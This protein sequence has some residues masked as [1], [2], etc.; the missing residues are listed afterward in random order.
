MMYDNPFVAYLN[1]YTTVS[2]EHEAA[3]DE[4]ITQAK[5][6]SGETLRLDTKIETFLSVVFARE[7]PTSVILTGNAGDGKTYLC[8]QIATK[9]NNGR[10]PK[11]WDSE[12]HWILDRPNHKLIVIKDLSE[13][14]EING[15]KLLKGLAKQYH[16]E[17]YIFLVAANEGR[18]RAVLAKEGL[19]ELENDVGIQLRDGPDIN[20]QHLVVL[21]LN[22]ITTSSFVP[23]VLAWLTDSQHWQACTGCPAFNACPIRFNA[24]RLAQEHVAERFKRLYQV[25][26]HLGIHVTIRDMLI[27]L[28]YTLTGSLK[29]AEIIS[30]SQGNKQEWTESASNH[31]YYENVWGEAADEDFQRKAIVVQNLRRLNVGESSVFAID[32][33]II[34]G[35]SENKDGQNNHDELFAPALDL[36]N[37]KFQQDRIAYLQGGATSPKPE[38]EHQLM[39]WLPHCRRKLFFE[40]RDNETA[41]RLFPFSFLRLYFQLL[42]GD[43][44]DLYKA[45]QDMMLGLNRTF[46]GLYL[47]DHDSLYVTSQYAHAVEQSVPIVQV[48]I[49]SGNIDLMPKSEETEAYNRD[50]KALQ[51]EILPPAR[52]NTLPIYWSMDLLR[53]EYLMRRARGGTPNILDSECELSIRKLKDDLLS[54]FISEDESNRI[55]FFAAD[56]NRYWLRS[57]WVDE[58]NRI[59]LGGDQ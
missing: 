6:P 28:T 15:A 44:A 30:Q 18:L 32:D 40:L 53:F 37:K 21:N 45:K 24:A 8:R 35:H 3:F 34:S 49:P 33:F 56:R 9:L 51:L 7:R 10:I 16:G 4:F 12:T 57:L 5:P 42:K 59:R 58:D 22:Q 36:G 20:N 11:N 50:L 26:E 1:R 17:K 23:Q 43:L 31:V 39:K 25:L 41:D 13:M 19:A 46:S 47:T 52:V 29:C 2:S 48:K 38:D 14:G 54:K 55:D 27:H